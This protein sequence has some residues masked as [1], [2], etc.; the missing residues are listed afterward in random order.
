M[1]LLV[2]YQTTRE[3]YA[4]WGPI[5]LR[6]IDG[7]STEPADI[8]RVHALL[9]EVLEQQPSC[10]MLLIAHHGSPSPSLA[11]MRYSNAVMSDIKD[12]LVVGIALLGL[13]FW[14]E[15]SRATTSALMR[16]TRSNVALES[17]PGSAAQRM[18]MELIG[19]DPNRLLQACDDLEQLFRSPVSSTGGLG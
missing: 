1:R 8:D 15:T 17:T 2:R 12:R 6:L 10:G 16:L 11:T 5:V 9:L 7:A 4:I 3:I 19:I 14:A 13:G 18:A